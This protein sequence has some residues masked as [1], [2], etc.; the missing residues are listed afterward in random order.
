MTTFTI[1][2]YV[3]GTWALDSAHSEIGF[4]ARHMMVSKVRGNFQT[5]AGTITTTP[6]PLDSHAE[7]QI[8]L[9]VAGI[10]GILGHQ[11]EDLVERGLLQ[12]FEHGRVRREKAAIGGGQWPMAMAGCGVKG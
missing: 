12:G 4:A 3:A 9:V 5:F 10:G 6:N 2:N 1:P 7:A 8:D 11:H